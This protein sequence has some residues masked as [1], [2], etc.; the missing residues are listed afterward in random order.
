MVVK[1]TPEILLSY[2][3]QQI[4]FSIKNDYKSYF[5]LVSGVQELSKHSSKFFCD[6]FHQNRNLYARGTIEGWVNENIILFLGK[7]FF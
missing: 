2:I 5:L 1:S 4:S 3:L 6:F 7:I